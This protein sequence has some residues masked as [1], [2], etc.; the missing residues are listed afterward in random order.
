MKISIL[1]NLISDINYINTQDLKIKI[2]YYLFSSMFILDIITTIIAVNIWWN[3]ANPI[4][5]YLVHNIPI[6]FILSKILILIF[7]TKMFI[8]DLKTTKNKKISFIIILWLWLFY[9]SIQVN[10]ILAIHNLIS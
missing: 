3:E 1:Q 5:H 2:S 10:N 4:M 8:K 9:L 6:L 7:I